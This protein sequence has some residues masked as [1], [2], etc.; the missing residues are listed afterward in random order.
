MLASVDLA[1]SKVHQVVGNTPIIPVRLTIAGQPVEVFLKLE[2][3]NPFGSIKDRTAFSLLDDLERRG[4]LRPGGTVVESSSGNLAV[5]LGHLCLDRGY[6]FIAVVD[7]KVT[8]ENLARLEAV[9]ARVEMVDTPD[10][11]G[12]YLLSRLERVQ[13]LCAKHPDYCWTN[14]Y[15]NPANPLA[16]FRGT[17]PEILHQM[18]GLVD[19]LV[20][21]VSTG[22][23]LSGIGR[24]F[25]QNSAR[26]TIIAVDA[27]GSIALGGE[28]GA[29]LLSGIGASRK[30]AFVTTA[31]FHRVIYVTDAQAFA[32]C[33]MLADSTGIR[34]GGSSGAVIAACALYLRQHPERGRI[35]CLC[36][37]RGDNYE[38]SIFSDEWL[39]RH[40]FTGPVDESCPIE[41][42]ALGE[43][44]LITN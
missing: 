32:I 39:T 37:D 20:I 23:M 42:V 6:R 10:A 36:A 33:N 28:P 40:G 38:S 22:G 11:A 17:A 16:H 13:A 8:A 9:G 12:G 34:V 31:D 2:G 5:A 14:Q 41:S 7:R 3:Y 30:S 24:Y 25:R 19:A 35:V 18:N 44:E 21:P 1:P 15:G 27:Q 4:L 29:R 26:T 43:L